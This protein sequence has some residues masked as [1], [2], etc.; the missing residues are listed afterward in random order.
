MDLLTGGWITV[1]KELTCHCAGVGCAG[2]HTRHVFFF[3]EMGMP[4]SISFEG[5]S[6]PSLRLQAEY[7]PVSACIRGVKVVAT[8]QSK[9]ATSHTVGHACLN[10]Y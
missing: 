4:S 6:R 9:Y 8:Q 3:A 1:F 7:I 10:M 5:A 2:H